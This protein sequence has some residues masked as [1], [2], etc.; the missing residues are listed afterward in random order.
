MLPVIICLVGTPINLT[1]GIFTT[2]T[3]LSA[4]MLYF[5]NIN[6]VW[7]S[8]PYLT[9]DGFASKENYVD[10]LAT[11]LFLHNYVALMYRDSMS[12]SHIILSGWCRIT[13]WYC[14]NSYRNLCTIW[15]KQASD[16][17][18][19]CIPLQSESTVNY[20]PYKYILNFPMTHL[21]VA[22][23]LTKLCLDFSSGD[24]VDIEMK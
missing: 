14:N 6:T 4:S 10:A 7:W 17:K 18:N 3:G 21:T 24:I 1:G 5:I 15:V 11:S 13:N 20:Y 12:H 2:G 16:P 22:A 19:F 23:S 9:I 8:A